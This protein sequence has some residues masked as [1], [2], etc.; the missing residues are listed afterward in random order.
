MYVDFQLFF[1]LADPQAVVVSNENFC[2]EIVKSPQRNRII[3]FGE[4]CRL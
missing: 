3:S 4:F 2:G 1:Y